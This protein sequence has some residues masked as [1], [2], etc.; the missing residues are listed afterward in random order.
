MLLL[1]YLDGL[2]KEVIRAELVLNRT[3]AGLVILTPI[4]ELEEGPRTVE[5]DIGCELLPVLVCRYC[6]SVH[7]NYVTHTLADGQII[8]LICEKDD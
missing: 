1:L 3:P 6:R 4:V 2:S 5:A 8:K 7:S